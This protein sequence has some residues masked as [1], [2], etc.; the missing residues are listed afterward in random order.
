M[1]GSGCSGCVRG[2]HGWV[3]AEYRHNDAEKEAGGN[4]VEELFC[5]IV[6]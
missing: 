2:S 1:A 4:V 3:R 6:D 5:E